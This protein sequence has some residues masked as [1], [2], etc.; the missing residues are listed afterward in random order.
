MYFWAYENIQMH[1]SFVE[2]YSKSTR[3]MSHSFIFGSFKIFV[4]KLITIFRVSY[5]IWDTVED[6]Y[7]NTAHNP[8]KF[9]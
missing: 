4:E 7:I 3:Y 5:D 2:I 9:I 1:T 8:L 6:K